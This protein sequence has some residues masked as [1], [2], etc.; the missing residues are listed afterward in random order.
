MF[1]NLQKKNKKFMKILS[2]L[3]IKFHLR[4]FLKY[5]QNLIK[6]W[7]N[8]NRI[9][10]KSTSHMFDMIS[11]WNFTLASKF[12]ILFAYLPVSSLSFIFLAIYLFYI[13]MSTS[14]RAK[15]QVVRWKFLENDK[16]KKKK[17]IA[18]NISW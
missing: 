9:Q 18:M 10:V 1:E 5:A 15:S 11:T 2:H 14:F 6:I 4:F 3:N 17:L 16:S 8:L 13:E 12:G 7:R